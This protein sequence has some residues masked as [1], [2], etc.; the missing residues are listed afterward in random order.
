MSETTPSDAPSS[1]PPTPPTPPTP[2]PPATSSQRRGNGR[3]IAAYAIGAVVLAIVAVAL[4][5]PGRSWQTL[6]F[7]PADAARPGAAG[8]VVVLQGVH[9]VR[10][11]RAPLPTDAA[12]QPDGKPT[13]VWFSG[14]WCT[15][16][17]SM[18]PYA[19]QTMERY[20]SRIA[21]VEKS[22]DHDQPA[23]ARYGVRG[24]PTFLLIDA[25]DKE[26]ARFTY[27]A[28]ATDFAQ[29]I[30]AALKKGGV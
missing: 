2:P 13:L 6:P 16:C 26:L 19:Q 11:S 12:R 27:A 28:N 14:T 17:A 8:E 30:E 7:E 18:E 25:T 5:F 21:L 15:T 24:T 1:E 22:V 10:H 3:R 4:V 29:Q 23:V 9:T 20:Q